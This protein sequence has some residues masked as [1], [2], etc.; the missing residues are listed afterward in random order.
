[1]AK[2]DSYFYGIGRRKSATA[3]ARVMS[4]KGGIIVNGKPAE[5][6]FAGSAPI[7]RELNEPLTVLGKT[8]DY[9]VTLVIT[10]GG[11]AGQ[12]D[13]ARLAIAKALSS[14]NDDINGSLRKVGLLKRDTREKERKKYGLRSARKREQFS[15]R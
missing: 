2:A 4:G 5:E 6:Y 1:M 15:K 13:A 14:I 12:V 3:R 9:T 8:S 11:H 10:G 7:L